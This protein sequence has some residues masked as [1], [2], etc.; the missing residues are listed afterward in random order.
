MSDSQE[1]DLMVRVKHLVGPFIDEI[2]P[3]TSVPAPFLAALTANESGAFLVHN[4]IIP[5]RSEPA[6]LKAL[7]GVKDGI[8]SGY[9]RVTP[10]MLGALTDSDLTK[11]ASSYGLTQIMG[12]H[13][14]V[15]GDCSLDDLNDPARHYHLTVRLLAEGAEEFGLDVTTEFEEMARFWNSGSPTGSTF[16]P[17]YVPNLLH[18]MTIWGSLV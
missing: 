18:R 16:D 3:Q 17:L 2:T 9:G 14:L 5:P 7:R 6:I 12:W 11:Y 4:T 8:R 10:Q 13:T 1:L 15:W